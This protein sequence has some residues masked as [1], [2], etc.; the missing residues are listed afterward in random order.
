M[1][2]HAYKPI[3][4]N[5][6]FLNGHSLADGLVQLAVEDMQKSGL[7]PETIK[8]AGVRIF[9]GN[10][11]D[12]IKHLGRETLSGHSILALSRLIEFPYYTERGD[13]YLYRYK[14][15]PSLSDK[16]GKEIKYL[17]PIGKPAI[18]YILPDIWKVK[19]KTNKSLWITEGE[20]KALALIQHGRFAIALSG[21]WNFKA[22]KNSD[23][24]ES[25]KSLWAELEAFQWRGRTVY[26]GF[27][28]DLW[29]NHRV[30]EALYELAIKL[31]ERKAIVRIAQW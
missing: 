1:T 11:E 25:D 4:D 2:G 14:L 28:N 24:I 23:E 27:D 26:M 6:R 22:G 21:I 30:R 17:H 15:I 3:E 20:K 8:N 31:Y 9:N 7:L 18:P 12:L 16:G 10:R 5:T 13:I 19:D 29:T